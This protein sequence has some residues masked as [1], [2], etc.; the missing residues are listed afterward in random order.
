MHIRRL[1][2]FI[3]PHKAELKKLAL[4]IHSN[5]EIGMEE[6]NAVKKQVEIL[7]KWGFDLTEHFCNIPTAFKATFGKGANTLCFMSEYDALP[8]LGHAC[9]HNL[10]AVTSM[11]ASKILSEIIKEKQLDAQVVLLGTPGEEGMGGKI[12]IIKKNGLAGIDAV[13]MAHP[14]NKTAVW[15]G[16]FG[17]RRFDI[18]FFGK[19]S[20]AADAP[21][22]GINALDAVIMLFNAVNAWREHLPENTRIHGIITNG[23]DAPNIVPEKASASFYLRAESQTTLNGMVERFEQMSK[24]AA[25]QTGCSVRHISRPPS[26]KTGIP[27]ETLNRLFFESAS[28]LNMS[29]QIPAITSRASTDFANVSHELPGIHAYFDITKKKPYALHTQEF[30]EAAK[31]S[32]AFDQAM[33]TASALAYTAYRYIVE[34]KSDS[35]PQQRTFR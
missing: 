21:E 32:Y 30:L 17:V 27:N 25:L 20:H 6:H 7:K 4:Y 28:E 33:K 3:N 9:G 29:P 18:D 2:N 26:Y 22:H 10:I 1:E 19:A 23:G 24:G 13:I 12:E 5:P 11:A 16:C 35:H 15:K 14:D 34:E 8:G 31:S